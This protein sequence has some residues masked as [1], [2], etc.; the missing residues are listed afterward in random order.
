M[1][2]SLNDLH[3]HTT[4]SDGALSPSELLARAAENG[5]MRLAITDHDTVAGYLSVRDSAL[6][7]SLQ[8]ISGVEIST[9]WNGIGIHVVG[10][11]FDAEHATMAQLLAKQAQVREQRAEIILQKLRKN[12]LPISM[13]EVIATAKTRHIGRPHIAAVMV[14][15]GYV[16][17]ANAAFKKYLGAGKIG[18]VKNGW[19]SIPTAVKAITDSGGVAVLAHPNHYKMT[20]TKLFVL[21]DE[22]QQAGGRA[23]EVI[24]GKQH[25]DIT[26]KFAQIARDKGFYASLGSD[27]HRPL[28][29]G[30]DVG[31]VAQ[32]PEDLSPVWVLF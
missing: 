25:R 29:Y 18:D 15:K 21:L 31:E 26:A 2:K 24:S 17:N 9:Q 23:I 11:N 6:A 10:L 20:R 27:F 19:A 1:E 28:S 32:L 22:F 7:Q 13:D 30:C 12:N 14:E 3:S 8:L 16:N 4:A 5:V